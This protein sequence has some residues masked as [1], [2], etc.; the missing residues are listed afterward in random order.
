MEIDK[1]RVSFYTSAFHQRVLI[2]FAA[3]WHPEGGLDEPPG[4]D[5]RA[6]I[7]GN[8][9]TIGGSSDVTAVVLD[10]P[11]ERTHGFSWVSEEL[12]PGPHQAW[13]EWQE[14]LG[15]TKSACI[16]EKSTRVLA[17]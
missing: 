11:G 1:T 7:D 8:V 14:V 10:T 9:V 6:V 3:T 12:H 17:P 13:I 15:T 4:A 16:I 5:V 2:D